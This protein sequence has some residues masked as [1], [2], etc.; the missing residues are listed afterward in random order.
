VQAG[1]TEPWEEMQI[2]LGFGDPLEPAADWVDY[3]H[4]LGPP[5]RLLA[6]RAETLIG[7]KLH[8]LF[9]HGL[10]RWRPKDLHD[11]LLLTR[12]AR[13]EPAALPAAIQTAFTSRGEP[14]AS[15]RILLDQPWWNQPCNCA[16]WDRFRQERAEWNIP[17]DLSAVVTQ[18]A[19]CLHPALATLGS[20]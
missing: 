9:E 18:V 6:C 7:W 17:A 8:G 2:D 3:P 10:K 12:H 4:L 5:S 11:L 1:V 19:G 13:F 20:W 15:L 14:L 16:R